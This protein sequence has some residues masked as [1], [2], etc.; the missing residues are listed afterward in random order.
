MWHFEPTMHLMGASIRDEI[1]STRESGHC[2]FASAWP[3]PHHLTLPGSPRNQLV[4][5]SNPWKAAFYSILQHSPRLGFQ[6]SGWFSPLGAQ[7][8]KPFMASRKLPTKCSSLGNP[9]P[10][11]DL[12]K[13]LH[14]VITIYEYWY[15]WS[16]IFF[17][18][19]SL[20]ITLGHQ[21]L[22]KET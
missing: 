16:I 22:L 18:P 19:Y 12:I 4:G 20:Q 13:K 2:G 9:H 21:K 5:I 10:K 1:S 11:K 15:P 14:F 3:H 8:L 6:H 17:P 7:V